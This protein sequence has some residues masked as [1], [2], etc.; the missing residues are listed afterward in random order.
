MSEVRDIWSELADRVGERLGLHFPAARRADLERGIAAAARMFGFDGA[1]PCARCLLAT[2]WTREQVDVLARHLTIGETYFYRD[3]GAFAALERDVLPSLLA[4]RATVRRLRIWSAGC[5]TGEEPY[6]IAMLLERAIP[7]IE[8]WNVSILATDIDPQALAKAARGVYGEWSFRDMPQSARAGFF[9][10]D[11]KGRWEI[12]Q[13]VRERVQFRGLNLAQDP[14]PSVENG[15]N[16]MDLIFCRNVLM[17]FEPTR[18]RAALRRLEHSLRDDGWLFVNPVEVPHVGLPGLEPVHFDGAIAH[19]KRGANVAVPVAN[20]PPA[21]P[22]PIAMPVAAR[23]PAIT[24]QE[25]RRPTA[26][27]AATLARQAQ[28]CANRGALEEARRWCERAIAA[29]KLDARSHFLLAGVLQE[30]RLGEE[31]ASA[32]RRTIYLEPRHVLAHYALGHL[33]RQGGRADEAARH[34][35][36][37][38]R[39]IGAWSP[40]DAAREFDGMDVQRLAEVIR[41]G[42]KV[43]EARA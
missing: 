42:M 31:A 34:F 8:R 35:R 18:A 28:D 32:L 24:R 10:R 17:Y 43:A 14:Y 29:D 12:A 16:A 15:T 4:A 9:E 13:R 1:E 40:Q 33:A 7:D 39:A 21:T 3:R 2:P 11:A 20:I 22:E 25:P 26:P 30:L 41:A 5:S 23:A 19:R 36:N 38:L 37:A 27:D 6:S